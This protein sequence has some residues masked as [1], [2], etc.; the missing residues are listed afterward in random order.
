MFLCI[1]VFGIYR[2]FKNPKFA[3]KRGLKTGVLALQWVPGHDL[4][5]SF[6]P[7]FHPF[8]APKQLNLKDF[9]DIQAVKIDQTGLKTG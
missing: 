2:V 8:L 1:C 3:H 7:T 6:P 4:K 9:W 5:N